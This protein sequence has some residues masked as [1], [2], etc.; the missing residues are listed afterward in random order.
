M[1]HPTRIITVMGVLCSII[2]VAVLHIVH[3]D[4]SALSD[5]LS[6]Y[7]N[8]S[9]GWLMATA[10]IALASGIAALGIGLWTWRGR[11]PKAWVILSTALLASV[12]TMLSGIF[13]TGGS[14]ISETIHSR[15]SAVAVVAIIALALTHSA[16]FA[17]DNSG[18]SS[19]PIGAAIAMLAAALVVIGPVLHHTR[20][21]GL[22]QRLLWITLSTWL[23][24][25]AWLNRP[26]PW[27]HRQPRD[28]S[29]PPSDRQGIPPSGGKFSLDRVKVVWQK[30]VSNLN[31]LWPH[32]QP[33]RMSN[34]RS[35]LPQVAVHP[36]LEDAGAYSREPSS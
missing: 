34:S 28:L 24:R 5:R 35:S 30:V 17:R 12:G 4:L 22:S 18:A 7:A 6:E 1:S 15:A 2:C 8:G 10:F 36:S 26:G 25:T 11:D 31:G 16:P 33:M 29:A 32:G 3:T 19:D 27:S 9:Y 21:T 20:W 14:D 23:L 13:R